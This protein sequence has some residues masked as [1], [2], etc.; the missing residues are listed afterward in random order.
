MFTTS[1]YDSQ[2]ATQ[3]GEALKTQMLGSFKVQIVPN[4][5][6]SWNTPF[7][8]VPVLTLLTAKE[9]ILEVIV[10]EAGTYIKMLI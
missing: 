9:E 7:L 8:K 6:L 2:I 3:F 5:I 1:E 4:L 10:G